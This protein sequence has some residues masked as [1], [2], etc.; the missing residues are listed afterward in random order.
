MLVYKSEIRNERECKDYISRSHILLNKLV[1]NVST[2]MGL[3]MSV[4]L[5]CKEL[6]KNSSAE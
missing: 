4:F 3:V 2:T 6:V 1:F 5:Y